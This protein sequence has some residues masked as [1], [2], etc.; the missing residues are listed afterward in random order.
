M[1]INTIATN[2][3]RINIITIYFLKIKHTREESEK[4]GLLLLKILSETLTI[5][6]T[7]IFKF[8]YF[9]SANKSYIFTYCYRHHLRVL[10]FDN[11]DN[12]Y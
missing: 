5:N 9:I 4:I 10:C 8:C 12:I 6:Y 11:D 2:K 7:N 3:P 1:I